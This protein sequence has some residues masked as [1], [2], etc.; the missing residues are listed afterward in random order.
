M[1]ALEIQSTLNPELAEMKSKTPVAFHGLW[2]KLQS[3][4]YLKHGLNFK[5]IDG[6]IRLMELFMVLSAFR[7]L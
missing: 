1:R 2:I 7:A 5:N 6:F 3:S 4:E